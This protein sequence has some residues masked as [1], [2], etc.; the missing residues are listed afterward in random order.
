MLSTKI[1]ICVFCKIC[2]LMNSARSGASNLPTSIVFMIWSLKRW[3]W[4]NPARAPVIRAGLI[5]CQVYA[6]PRP[7]HTNTNTLWQFWKRG[8]L[9]ASVW[10]KFTWEGC[11]KKIIPSS[12]YFNLH[13]LVNR[14]FFSLPMW[15]LLT[16]RKDSSESLDWHS[17]SRE[18]LGH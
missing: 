2:S 1:S 7:E 17:S 16:S 10:R 12:L 15:W 4:T 14:L 5:S 11:T 9:N 3:N 13:G 8:A 18:S 6:I